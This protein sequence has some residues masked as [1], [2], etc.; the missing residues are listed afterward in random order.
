MNKPKYWD[1]SIHSGP[2]EFRIEFYMED[3]RESAL[4]WIAGKDGNV[5]RIGEKVLIFDD[6]NDDSYDV[7]YVSEVLWVFGSSKPGGFYWGKRSTVDIILR[8]PLPG[9]S[10]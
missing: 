8:E 7:S 1:Q 4:F 3:D 6:E 5:P 2:E 9:E 10:T